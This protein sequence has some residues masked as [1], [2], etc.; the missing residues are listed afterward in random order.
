[1]EYKLSGSMYLHEMD[2]TLRGMA[3]EGWEIVQ[4]V[5]IEWST[6]GQGQAGRFE[7]GIAVARRP[8]VPGK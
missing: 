7:R 4:V 3:A 5:P 2:K 6:T 8:I 1:M